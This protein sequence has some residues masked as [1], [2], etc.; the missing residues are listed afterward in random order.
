MGTVS[1]Y[2]SQT[3]SLSCGV[4][5]SVL[6]SASTI[7]SCFSLDPNILQGTAA[8]DTFFLS[9]TNQY[10]QMSS[11]AFTALEVGFGGDWAMEVLQTDSACPAVMNTYMWISDTHVYIR[12]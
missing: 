9:I 8:A 1:D 12:V 6:S 2:S 11:D 10:S 4:F 3:F 7:K 5:C